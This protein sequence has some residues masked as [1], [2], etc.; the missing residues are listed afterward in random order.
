MAL[1]T[2]IWN[3]GN[4]LLTNG[5]SCSKLQWVHWCARLRNTRIQAAGMIP[6]NFAVLTAIQMVLFGR[7]TA[8]GRKLFQVDVA[9]MRVLILVLGKKYIQ[10]NCTVRSG[11]R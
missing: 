11:N 7:S 2:L 9:R 10:L 6:D 1:V 3:A 8:T 5:K 4:E